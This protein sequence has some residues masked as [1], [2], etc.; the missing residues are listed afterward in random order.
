MSKYLNFKNSL[1]NVKNYILNHKKISIASAIIIA[2]ALIFFGGK[3]FGGTTEQQYTATKV[4]KGDLNITITGSGQV[5]TLSEVDIKPNTVGQTQTLGQIV[6]VKVKNGDMVKAGQVIAVLDG[7]NALQTFNQAKASV[8]SAQ[9]SY[10]KLLNGPTESELFS[11]KNSIKNASTTLVNLKLNTLIKLK[12]A[13]TSAANSIYMNTDPLLTNPMTTSPVLTPI[14]G[15]IFTDSQYVNNINFERLTI[16]EKL[17][18]LK[19]EL[20]SLDGNNYDV[21]ATINET[22][23]V[24][25]E[26]RTYFDDMAM[27]FSSY[28]VAGDTTSQNTVNSYK[29]TAASARSSMDSLISDLTTT[30]QSYNSAIT[31][32]EQ[33][34]EQY[35]LKIAPPSASDITVSKASLDNAKA[36]Y[37]NAL[38]NY[39]S[40]IITA[41]FDGQ[42]GGLSVQ[43]GQTVSSNDSLGKII[44]SEKVVNLSLNEVDAAKVKTGD[45]VSLTFDA[46][47]N[48]T[49]TGHV[50]YIDPLGVVSQGVVSYTVNISI[51]QNDSQIKT[52]MTA[53]AS[54]TTE[55][56]ENVLM[57][58][59]TAIKTSGTKKYVLVPNI[60]NT[61]NQNSSSSAQRK[62]V[63]LPNTTE[64]KQVEV[65]VG[66]TNNT[67]TEIV[68]G[69]EEG[70]LV[71]TKT[72][73]GT[74]NATKSTAAS[75]TTNERGGMMMGGMGGPGAAGF[76]KKNDR[77]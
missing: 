5:E 74:T 62:T 19:T 33:S 28:S 60:A 51:D 67:Y 15:V 46:I 35:A 31:S 73:T 32:L 53:S 14:S 38:Q 17:A 70:Q 66:I 64:L 22:L 3:I 56:K 44:T 45:K 76:L 2:V 57:V 21:L 47:P 72:S 16:G 43:V 75:A 4:T 48:L 27:L 34:E 26:M 42:I 65:V 13:Y 9:A 23:V 24:L 18:G 36:N 49:V 58:P 63:S 69:L 1:L 37:A 59:S 54:I 61:Q 8:D 39:Q 29:S 10:D 77:M 6:S 20:Y 25:N 11:L 7:E 12:N 50:Q 40:R 71:I 41:P 30:I 68:S 55:S 52:G